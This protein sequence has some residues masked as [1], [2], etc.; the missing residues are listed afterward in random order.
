MSRPRDVSAVLGAAAIF[1]LAQIGGGHAQSVLFH[2]LST[3]AST[4]PD[5]GT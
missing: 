5:N 2:R 1:T 4:V 3:I